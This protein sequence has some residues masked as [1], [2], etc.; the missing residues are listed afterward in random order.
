MYTAAQFLCTFIPESLAEHNFDVMITHTRCLMVAFRL[1]F[2]FHDDYGE[3]CWADL[4][5]VPSSAKEMKISLDFAS[6]SE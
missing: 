6:A 3:W 2:H 5:E 1:L 4:A